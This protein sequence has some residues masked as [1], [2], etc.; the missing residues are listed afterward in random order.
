[1]KVI[2]DAERYRTQIPHGGTEITLTELA[3]ATYFSVNL[4][5][6]SFLP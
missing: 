1:M 5:M 6:K 2:A 3:F 4:S